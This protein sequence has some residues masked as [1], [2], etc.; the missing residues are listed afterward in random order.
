MNYVYPAIFE[1]AAEGGFTISFP[2]LPGC[3][4]QGNDL[5]EALYMAQSALLQWL[6]CLTDKGHEIPQAS[7]V[8]DVK[9]N[10]NE[11][12]NLICAELKD[13]RSVRRSVSLPKWM[14]D[15]AIGAGLSLSRVLQDALTERLA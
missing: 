1:S 4:S 10:D 11:F 9:F 8:K 5:S 2:D 15:K 7:G 12:V 6:E 3:Y 13:N 14:D